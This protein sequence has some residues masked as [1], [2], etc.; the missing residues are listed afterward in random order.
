MQKKQN[1]QIK[2]LKKETILWKQRYSKML[3]AYFELHS[4]CTSINKENQQ[5]IEKTFAK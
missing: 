2:Q 4:Y 1:Q 5:E 3:I